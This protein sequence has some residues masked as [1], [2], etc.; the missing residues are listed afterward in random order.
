V[1]EVTPRVCFSWRLTGDL[2]PPGIADGKLGFIS[3][4]IGD[5]RSSS[6]EDTDPVPGNESEEAVQEEENWLDGCRHVYV[7]LGEPPIS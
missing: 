5:Q 6:R 4:K 1:D 7:D 2:W 3:D